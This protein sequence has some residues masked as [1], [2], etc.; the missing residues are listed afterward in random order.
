MNTT[1]SEEELI[2]LK[3]RADLMGIKYSNNI[4]ISTLKERINE[5][6]EGNTVE[7]EDVQAMQPKAN[8][9]GITREEMYNEQMKLVRLRITCMNPD[10]SDLAGEILTVGNR[11]LGTVRKF[12]PYGEATD[13][14]YHVPYILYNFMK[15]RKYLHKGEK[16]DSK[17][18]ITISTRWVP[19]YSLEV[20]PQLTEKELAKLA[21]SQRARASMA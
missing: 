16:R 20:L 12:V 4:S 1:A 18:N 21:A 3:K 17:G 15:D 6:L 2:A 13:N 5:H 11:L 8:P 19:E 7:E 14:G 9:E 10:K